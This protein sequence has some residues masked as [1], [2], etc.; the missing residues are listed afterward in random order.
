MNTNDLP[1][2]IRDRANVAIRQLAEGERTGR[3]ADAVRHLAAFDLVAVQS[4]LLTELLHTTELPD[5][6]DAMGLFIGKCHAFVTLYDE[7]QRRGDT[8]RDELQRI[9]DLH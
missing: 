7:V 5:T 9:T 4:L 2:L 3:L 8:L 6:T 1:G